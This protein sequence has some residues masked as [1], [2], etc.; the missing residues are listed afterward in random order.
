MWK[1][2]D[3]TVNVFVYLKNNIIYLGKSVK[4]KLLFTMTAYQ[5]AKG[6]LRG[7]RLGLKKIINR[8]KHTSRT[9]RETPQHYIKRD[10]R[11]QHTKVAT[12][13]NTAW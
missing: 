11:Q 2:G 8:T 1:P 9:T 10:L 3:A 6:L 4:N 12:H 7:R 13:D 5:K